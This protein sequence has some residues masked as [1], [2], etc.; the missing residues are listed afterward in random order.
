MVEMLREIFSAGRFGRERE[1][2]DRETKKRMDVLLL[3]C[4]GASLIKCVCES[5]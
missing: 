3:H 5:L 1:E 2:K 4:C